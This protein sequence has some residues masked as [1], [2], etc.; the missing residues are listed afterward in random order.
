MVNALPSEEQAH[1]LAMLTEQN[2]KY[3]D[4]QANNL[5]NIALKIS[6]ALAS[7]TKEQ[8]IAQLIE[9]GMNQL[10]AALFVQIHSC[11]V[12]DENLQT[13]LMNAL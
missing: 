1:L 11:E 6:N 4:L 13:V 3:N 8:V 9:L 2:P 7:H 5:T 12:S 10:Y